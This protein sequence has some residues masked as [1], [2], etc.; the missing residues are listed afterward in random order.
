MA[1]GNFDDLGIFDG[2]DKRHRSGWNLAKR[3]DH[4]RMAGMA[5]EKDVPAFF[6]QALGLAMDLGH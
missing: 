2:L 4:F 3:A 1:G 6:D 5:D